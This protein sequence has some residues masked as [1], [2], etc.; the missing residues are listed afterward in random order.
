MAALEAFQRYT[1]DELVSLLSYWPEKFVNGMITMGDNIARPST[2]CRSPAAAVTSCS[3]LERLPYELLHGILESLDFRTLSHLSRTSLRLKAAAES[4]P[5]YRELLAHAPDVLSA[6][7]HSGLITQH[8]A[9]SLCTAL[10]ASSCAYCG[11][12]GPFLFLFTA[13]RC[14]YECLFFKQRLGVVPTAHALQQF[15]L[16]RQEVQQLPSMRCLR[17]RYFS[18]ACPSCSFRLLRVPDLQA[19]HQALYG[20]NRSIGRMSDAV[21]ALVYGG[22]RLA[23]HV[24]RRHP[25]PEVPLEEFAGMASIAFGS[26]APPDH[27]ALERGVWCLGCRKIYA[28]CKIRGGCLEGPSVWLDGVQLTFAEDRRLLSLAQRSWPMSEFL[29]HA[30]QCQGAR[31]ILETEAKD[32]GDTD[33]IGGCMARSK[34][35]MLRQA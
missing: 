26:L 30:K 14:C 34:K 6:L 8:S 17:G 27:R 10:H 9:A 3:P 5:A 7:G 23:G 1:P 18:R 25:N 11:A 21:R 32:R 29:A 16:S 24:S 12:F 35:L 13:E 15:R 19:R 22:R 31:E 4:L 28:R 20:S 2:I 33:H